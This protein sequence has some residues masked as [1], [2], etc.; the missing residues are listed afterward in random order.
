MNIFG[1]VLS[2]EAMMKRTIGRDG[3]DSPGDYL[4]CELDLRARARELREGNYTVSQKN[5][6]LCRALAKQS[7]TFFWDTV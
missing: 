3:C 5:V 4:I 1:S 6:L 2:E 7:K